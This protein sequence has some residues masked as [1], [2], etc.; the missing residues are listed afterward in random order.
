[1]WDQH[2]LYYEAKGD[3]RRPDV[4][5]LEELLA[6]ISQWRQEGNEVIL[7]LDANQHVYDGY[8][9][10]TLRAEPFHMTCLLQS[11]T[12]SPVPNSHF[13][14]KDP[15]TTIFGSN[16]LTVGDGL[17]LVENILALVLLPPA[18]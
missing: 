2:K 8:L 17:C 5:M 13:R 12:G 1:V 18:S 16:G 11:A 10:T 9:G 7:A 6:V 3:F 15:I 4:I 14:G